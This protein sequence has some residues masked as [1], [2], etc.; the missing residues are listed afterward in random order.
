M[1]LDVTDPGMGGG[2]HTDIQNILSGGIP[3]NP[4]F[5]IVGMAGYPPLWPDARSL[6]PQVVLMDD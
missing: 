2:R 5:F 6:P 4:P 1:G 3:G